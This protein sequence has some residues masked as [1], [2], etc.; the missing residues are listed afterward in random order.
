MALVDHRSLED[1]IQR[2]FTA[3]RISR[4]TSNNHVPNDGTDSPGLA[5]MEMN[6]Q[7]GEALSETV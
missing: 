5:Y 4:H 3:I 6:A 7:N 1:L 2:L